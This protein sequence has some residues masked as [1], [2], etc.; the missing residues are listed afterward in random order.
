MS[1]AAISS[2]Q[3]LSPAQCRE[4]RSLLDW[5]EGALAFAA[6]VPVTLIVDFELG[7]EVPAAAVRALRTV[8]ERGGAEFTADAGPR[9]VRLR[10][11]DQGR[12]G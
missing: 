4:G 11:G 6:R 10:I 12:E 3:V 5:D 7:A 1:E 8:L 2:D 9:G